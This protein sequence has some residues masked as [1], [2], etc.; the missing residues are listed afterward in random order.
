M[1][2]PDLSPLAAQSAASAHLAAHAARMAV[3]L[4]TRRRRLTAIAFGGGLAVTADEALPSHGSLRTEEGADV[5]VVGRDPSTD[6]ALLRVEGLAASAMPDGAGASAGNVTVVAGMREGAPVARFGTVSHV[7]PDW[8]SVRGGAV[9]PRIE[10][11]LDLPHELEGAPAVAADGTLLGMAVPGP[12]DQ[13]L[14]IP[15]ATIARV[16]RQLEERGNIPRGYLGL[17]LHPMREEDGGMGLRV[18]SVEQGGPGARAGVRQGDVILGMDG[19]ALRGMRE[20]AR[21]LGPDSVGRTMALDIRR[22]EERVALDLMV[23][24]RA[25]W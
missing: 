22:G 16:A 23:G 10:L 8:R 11:D 3:P 19:A 9:G 7:G 1:P 14:V 24:E 18:E 4:R 21:T 25:Q 20:L 12:R 17:S 15:A 6:I 2:E 5:S 13:V